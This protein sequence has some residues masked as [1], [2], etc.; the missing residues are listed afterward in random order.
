MGGMGFSQVNPGQIDDFQN[1][2]TENWTDG[3]S[4]AQPFNVANGGPNGAG[5]NY[6]SDPALGGSGPGSRMVMFNEQQWTGNY[7]SNGIVT[8]RFHAK[9]QGNAL[10]LRVAFDGAGGRICT[11]NAVPIP[12]DGSWQQYVISITGADFT[13]VAGGTNIG[14]TLADVSDMRIL[15]NT[16]PSWQGE[17]IVATLDI[18]NIE[19]STTLGIED[20]VGDLPV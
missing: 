7:T 14:D 9:A 8:I 20:F 5:D 2:T 16:V 10:N 3:G 15:S 13:T 1:G 19:A 11:T 18:D 12:A 17:S 4:S 6:L